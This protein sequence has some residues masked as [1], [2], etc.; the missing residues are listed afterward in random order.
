MKSFFQKKKESK[1]EDNVSED[2]LLQKLPGNVPLDAE[3]Y[4]PAFDINDTVESQNF[5]RKYGFVIFKNVLNEEEIAAATDVL[6]GEN[7][8]L[9]RN[10]RS[11]WEPFFERQ[12][13]GKMGIIGSGASLSIPELNNRQNPNVFRCFANFL[14][15]EDLIVDHDRLGNL[16]LIFFFFYSY[17]VLGLM[18]PTIEADG[19]EHPEWRTRARW[20]HLDCNPVRGKASIGSFADSHSLINFDQTLIPQGVLAL[21]DARAQDGGFHCVPGGHLISQKWAKIH[22]EEQVGGRDMQVKADDNLMTHIQKIPLRKG[23]LLLW[24]SLLFHGNHPNF[25]EEFRICQY[26]RMVPKD[27]TPY[28]PLPIQDMFPEG[29]EVSELGKKLFDL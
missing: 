29:F 24:T 15:S 13:F 19:T 26:I 8:K 21:S 22:N 11:T 16:N 28:L 25:S 17:F 1:K 12:P 14:Q 23:S 2:D 20:L 4:A 10:D 3:G 9:D 18:R 5:Q 6:F 7:S 27:Q